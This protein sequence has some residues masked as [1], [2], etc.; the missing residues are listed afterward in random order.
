MAY[1]LVEER[2]DQEVGAV[3]E[4]LQLQGRH[5]GLLVGAGVL[6]DTDLVATCLPVAALLL[7]HS[8]GF[9]RPSVSCGSLSR[10]VPFCGSSYTYHVLPPWSLCLQAVWS[11]SQHMQ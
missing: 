4:K 2:V 8:S 1:L 9:L 6:Q 10:S 3:V 7:P 5:A 11:E